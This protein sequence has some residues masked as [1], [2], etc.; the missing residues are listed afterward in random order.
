MAQEVTHSLNDSCRDVLTELL[1][2][3]AGARMGALQVC[4]ALQGT[5][6]VPLEHPTHAS[7]LPRKYFLLSA[8]LAGS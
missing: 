8:N 1:L 2:A 6:E 3:S 7:S 5:V 4:A